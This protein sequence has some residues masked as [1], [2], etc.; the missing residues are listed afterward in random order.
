MN[1]ELARRLKD[2]GFPQGGKGNWVLPPESIVVRHSDRVYVP[3]LEEIIELVPKTT[4]DGLFSMAKRAA[5][6]SSRRLQRVASSMMADRVYQGMLQD[7]FESIQIKEFHRLNEAIMWLV[8]EFEA[9]DGNAILGEIRL[10]GALIWRK[11]AFR[12]LV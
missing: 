4:N 1:Y 9:G 12:I 6:H 3:S 8:Q 5:V 7:R 10:Q 2:A 11:S